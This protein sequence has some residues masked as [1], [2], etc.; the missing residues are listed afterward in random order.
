MS[1]NK[2]DLGSTLRSS[3]KKKDVKKIERIVESVHEEKI[4]RLIVEV[5]ESLH[6]RVKLN[7]YQKGM[8][9][10]EYII[11]LLQDDMLG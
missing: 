1:K 3:K 10:K 7:A 11:S 6:Q 2:I 8:T 9:M 5:P 4:K